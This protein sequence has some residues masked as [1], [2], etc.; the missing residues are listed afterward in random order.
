MY[1]DFNFSLFWHMDENTI[2]KVGIIQCCKYIL[3]F[4]KIEVFTQM[5]FHRFIISILG[6]SSYRHTFRNI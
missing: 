2:L 5:V 6:K 1:R 3:L 4:I